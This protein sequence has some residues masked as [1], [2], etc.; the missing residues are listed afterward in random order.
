[1]TSLISLDLNFHVFQ[2]LYLN[3]DKSICGIKIKI[4]GNH[5]WQC[6]QNVQFFFGVKMKTA[7]LERVNFGT[8]SDTDETWLESYRVYCLCF[9][10]SRYIEI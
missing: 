4:Y 1:M 3:I 6:F 5:F 9:S 10:D 8:R 7:L 2:F